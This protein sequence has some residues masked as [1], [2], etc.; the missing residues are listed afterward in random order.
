LDSIKKLLEEVKEVEKIAKSEGKYYNVF[1]ILKVNEGNHSRF[2]ADL[3]NPKGI[4]GCNDIFLKL[5]F[6]K[7]LPDK[8]DII[9]T[10]CKVYIE[11]SIADG[12]LDIYIN[13]QD[14]GIVIE[15]KSN[16]APDGE[17]QL[18]RYNKFLQDG[19]FKDNYIFYLT[20]DGREASEQSYGQKARENTKPLSY[21]KDILEWL[22]CCQEKVSGKNLIWTTLEQYINLNLIGGNKMS[23]DVVETIKKDADSMRAAFDIANDIEVLKEGVWEAFSSSLEVETYKLGFEFKIARYDPSNWYYAAIRLS[24]PKEWKK[25]GITID[26]VNYGNQIHCGFISWE[27]C[28]SLHPKIRDKFSQYNPPYEKNTWCP[29]Y[30]EAEYKS[31]KDFCVAMVEDSNAVIKVFVDKINELLKII[32]SFDEEL[33]KL[34]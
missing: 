8:S 13:C 1:E 4:H 24:K 7:F 5:F 9:F 18:E 17:H 12:R 15:N 22:K 27:K 26:F 19:Q 32:N 31:Y 30:N 11:H 34:L 21:K 25:L 33:K 3:L 20:P 2:L 14:F 10:K 28:K 6:E 29:I 16:D 23:K